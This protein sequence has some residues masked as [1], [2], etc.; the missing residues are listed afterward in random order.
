M[1]PPGD[2]T[3]RGVG[4]AGGTPENASGRAAAEIEAAVGEFEHEFNL[5]MLPSLG[6]E[7]IVKLAKSL[8]VVHDEAASRG[9]VMPST[10]GPWESMDIGKAV[11]YLDE[12]S[13]QLKLTTCPSARVALRPGGVRG[14]RCQTKRRDSAESRLVGVCG[15]HARERRVYRVRV[16]Q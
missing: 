5:A 9:V 2:G 8:Q 4:A 16:W 6:V 1:P 10:E 11:A 14:A 15:T 13:E 12:L 3:P 7:E